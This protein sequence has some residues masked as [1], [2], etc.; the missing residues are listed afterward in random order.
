MQKR[1]KKRIIIAIGVV[2]GILVLGYMNENLHNKKNEITE[3]TAYFNIQGNEIN[4]HNEIQ[5]EIAKRTG[6]RCR[7][8]WLTGEASEEAINKMIANQEYTDFISGSA[9]LYEAG[10]LIPIDLY[11]DDYPNI[12]NFQSEEQWNHYRQNDGHIYWIPQFGVANGDFTSA[13]HDG[14]A[15]WI[16]TRVLKWAGYPSITTLEEYFSLI[17]AYLLE[18]P[19]LMSG[20]SNIGYTILCD[21]WRYFC[22]ENVPQFLDGYPNDGSV[23]VDPDTL[24]IIDYNT[25]DTAKRYFSKLNEMYRKGIVDPESFTQTYEE[26][27]AKLA[28]GRV[29]GMVD[30]WW[31]FSYDI[32]GSLQQQGLDL[33]GCNY[34][35]LPITISKEIKNQWNVYAGNLLTTSNGISITTSCTKPKEALQFI[36]DLLSQEIQ[37]LRYWGIEG[38][39]YEVNENGVF[40]RTEEQRKLAKDSEYK[41]N[42][43]CYYSFF[44]RYDGMS[45]DG[46]N[47]VSPEIQQTEFWDCLP[48]DVKECFEAY[49][50]NTYTDMIGINDVPGPWFP[51]Y[52]HSEQLTSA[53]E[54]GVVW[55]KM[56]QIKQQNLPRVVMSDEF[57]AAWESYMKLYESC[58]PEIFL[59][60]MQ[61]ALNDRV[62]SK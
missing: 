59:E 20:V 42:H 52:S 37:I 17:E 29:L 5:E 14:Q 50:C 7:E 47:A 33:L 38:I 4:V 13:L 30:Q 11:W 6:V 16:Q 58:N 32:N 39:D 10:A 45:L 36:N 8:S 26:Y 35:P 55:K 56:T 44:P 28:T 25:T 18:N 27:L 46:K 40:Y 53:S 22:F 41:A 15:F 60:E 48:S 19:E 43:L 54:A 2:T 57:E 1:I 23:I 9:V 12:K 62:D 49:D 21:D 24:Q 61:N 31:Q 51:M 3:F 34:V